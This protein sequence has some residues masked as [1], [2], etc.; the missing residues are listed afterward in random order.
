MT[1]QQQ[2]QQMPRGGYVTGSRTGS[3]N[4]G[5]QYMTQQQHSPRQNYHTDNS[6]INRPYGSA[7]TLQVNHNALAS[8]SGWLI[9]VLQAG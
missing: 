3:R 7:A 6:A 9:L 8:S 1:S 2:Q 4:N 5:D